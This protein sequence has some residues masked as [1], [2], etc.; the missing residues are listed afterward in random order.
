[1]TSG[2]GAHIIRDFYE[3]RNYLHLRR[4]LKELQVE[5]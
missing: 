1:M 4:L 5:A 3:Y 2:G